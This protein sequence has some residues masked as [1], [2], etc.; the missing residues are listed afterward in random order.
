[1]AP[2]HATSTTPDSIWD[3][4]YS[5]SDFLPVLPS[6][7]ENPFYP[8]IPLSDP[9]N[10]AQVTTPCYETEA[11]NSF[12]DPFKNEDVQTA[13]NNIFSMS[14][15]L[16][17]RY[18]DIQPLIPLP[19]LGMGYDDEPYWFPDLNNQYPVPYSSTSSLSNAS[20]TFASSLLDDIYIQTG[21]PD[22]SH[23]TM[24]SNDETTSLLPNDDARASFYYYCG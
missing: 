4:L 7:S 23:A 9:N 16:L 15:Y 18:A 19:S 21:T 13:D 12:Y 1:V 11:P 3:S 14:N 24:I 8:Q 5:A 2:L 10:A 6:E 17:G 20:T 22:S